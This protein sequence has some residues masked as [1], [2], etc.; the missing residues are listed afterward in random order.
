[1]C[2]MLTVFSALVVIAILLV[3]ALYVRE[4]IEK[5][6]FLRGARRKPGR[7]PLN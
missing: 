2:R 6:G 1:M 7:I 4:A 5:R 3:G